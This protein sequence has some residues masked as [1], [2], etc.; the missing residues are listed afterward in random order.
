M[1][2]VHPDNKGQWILYKVGGGDFLV[3]AWFVER[4]DAE[5]ARDAFERLATD[6]QQPASSDYPLPDQVRPTTA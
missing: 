4:E 6:R 2:E 5:F 1:Y 3:V